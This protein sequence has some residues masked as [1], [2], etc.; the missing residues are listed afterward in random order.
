[1]CHTNG[2][3][4]VYHTNNTVIFYYDDTTQIYRINFQLWNDY[5]KTKPGLSYPKH[6]EVM[7]LLLEN[8]LNKT[9]PVISK[10]HPRLRYN[11]EELLSL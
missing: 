4:I 1:V 6:L 2:G 11:I 10:M 9:I 5:L 8:Y 7:H 3:E